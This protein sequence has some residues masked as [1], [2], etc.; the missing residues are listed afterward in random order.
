MAPTAVT[1]TPS[2]P[3]AAA[4]AD[5]ASGTFFTPQR[6]RVLGYAGAAALVLAAAAWFMVTASHRKEQYAARALDEARNAAEQGNLGVAVQGFTKVVTSY[7]GTAAAYEAS[8]GI[9]QARMISGQNELAI[10]SLED[11]LKTNPPAFYAAPAYGLLGT[12]YENT[13]RW[14]DALAAHRKSADLAGVEYLK[15]SAL[16]DAGRSARLAGKRDEAIAIYR[17]ILE[18]HGKTAA[19]TEAQIR[20]AELTGGKF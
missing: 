19:Q 20:L 4:P 2:A 14:A 11:F 12:A 18:K 1:Q 17:E 10:S 15:A 5:G 13:A 6:L 9:A 3:P 7:K 8:L 16:L